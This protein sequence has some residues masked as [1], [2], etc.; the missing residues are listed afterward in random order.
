MGKPERSLNWD[1]GEDKGPRKAPGRGLKCTFVQVLQAAEDVPDRHFRSQHNLPGRVPVPS[2]L[3]I[4]FSFFFLFLFECLPYPSLVSNSLCS[5]GACC[6]QS[7]RI[8]GVAHHTQFYLEKGTELRPSCKLGKHSRGRATP[9]S[10]VLPRERQSMG[11]CVCVLL[12]SCDPEATCVQ[13]SRAMPGSFI[14]IVI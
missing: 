10:P 6:L 5:R 9:W 1:A 13:G 3:V 7:A 8:T 4:S 14:S 12:P 11:M 2:L